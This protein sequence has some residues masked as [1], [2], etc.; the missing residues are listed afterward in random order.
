MAA[1]T[2]KIPKNEIM[3]SDHGK[4]FTHENTPYLYRDQSFHIKV[5]ETSHYIAFAKC[6]PADDAKLKSIFAKEIVPKQR[7]GFAAMDPEKHRK[8]AEM[9]G[10]AVSKDTEYMK[11]IGRKGGKA[12]PKPK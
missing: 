10:L 6:E 4:W 8:I 7:K 3:S 12:K 9:G 2:I 1:I 5:G 11:R